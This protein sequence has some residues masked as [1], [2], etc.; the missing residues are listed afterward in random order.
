MF[1]QKVDGWLDRLDKKLD[2]DA[3][4]NRALHFDAA[5]HEQELKATLNEFKNALDYH[6]RQDEYRRQMKQAVQ[7]LEEREAALANEPEV[8]ISGMNL[9]ELMRHAEA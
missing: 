5:V 6:K 3:A 2:A 4:I 1:T 7:R 9:Q 8:D